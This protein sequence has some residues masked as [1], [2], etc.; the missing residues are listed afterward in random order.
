VIAVIS[1][2]TTRTIGRFWR[3]G[4]GGSHRMA[5]SVDVALIETRAVAHST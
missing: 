5:V 3:W 1:E 2:R 4:R